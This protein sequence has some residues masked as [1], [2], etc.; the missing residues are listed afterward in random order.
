MQV[1]SFSKEN[2]TKKAQFATLIL[3]TYTHPSLNLSKIPFK[4]KKQEYHSCNITEAPEPGNVRCNGINV[5]SDL[6]PEKYVLNKI[7]FL[8]NFHVLYPKTTL[9][10]ESFLPIWRRASPTFLL[11]FPK[12]P[13]ELWI[14]GVILFKK[15]IS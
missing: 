14:T 9:K 2:R 1:C 13:V 6:N 8:Y 5:S 10:S 3:A 12:L 15:T 4:D 11:L 7:Y